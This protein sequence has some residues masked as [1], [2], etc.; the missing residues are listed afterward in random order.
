MKRVI[1]LK[2]VSS[3]ILLFEVVV[4]LVNLIHELLFKAHAL[5]FRAFFRFVVNIGHPEPFRW[6]FIVNGCESQ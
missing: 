4:I 2:T 1:S 5:N 3:F 6:V